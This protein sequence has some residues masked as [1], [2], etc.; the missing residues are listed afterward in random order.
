MPR[1]RRE[2]PPTDEVP[3]AT[4][5]PR[6]DSIAEKAR[7]ALDQALSSEAAAVTSLQAAQEILKEFEGDPLFQDEQELGEFAYKASQA[8]IVQIVGALQDTFVAYRRAVKKDLV[9]PRDLPNAAE[10]LIGQLR[11]LTRPED[12]RPVRRGQHITGAATVSDRLKEARLKHARL[13]GQT[14]PDEP[15]G[16]IVVEVEPE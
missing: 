1:A 4:A 11:Q 10:S 5:V 12:V 13:T 16:E 2:R 15:A 7:M 9:L 8:L 6:L 14:L 3:P